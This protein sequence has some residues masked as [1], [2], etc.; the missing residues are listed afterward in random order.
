MTPQALIFGLFWRRGRAFAT[1]IE[2]L[3]VEKNSTTTIFRKKHELFLT[4]F[5]KTTHAFASQTLCEEN[6]SASEPGETREEP[7]DCQ[8]QP[9]RMIMAPPMTRRMASSRSAVS[10]SPRK[11]TAMIMPKMTEVSRRAATRAM[12]ASVMAQMAMP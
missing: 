10:R 11:M 9:R 6:V 5:A 8:P 3:R 1:K 12:G 4:Y 2:S 7:H